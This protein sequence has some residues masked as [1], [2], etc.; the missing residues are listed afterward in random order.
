MPDNPTSRR[1]L[2]TGATG[3]VGG[4]VLRKLIATGH[5]PV[6]LVRDLGKFER[7]TASLS[8]SEI[9]G[10]EGSI[11]SRSAL[12]RAAEQSDSAIHLV[13]VIMERGKQT[14]SRVHYEGTKNVLKT[15]L[16][17]GIKRYI[18]MSALGARPDA[19]SKYH[20]TKYM[21][22]EAV[23][24]SGLNWTIFQ[25]SV[26]HGPDGEFMELMKTFAC[27]LLPPVMPYFGDGSHRL[28]PVDVR[29]V[30]ECFVKALS[31]VNTIHRTYT[32]GGPRSFSWK[33][34]YQTCQRLIPG[35]KQWKPTIGQPVALAKFLAMTV[36][37]LPM[38]IAK[39][40]K[41]RFNTAQVQMSQEDSTCDIAPAESDLGISFRDFETE[42]AC[43][44]DQIR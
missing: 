28:Q 9:V 16:D 39:F 5:V 44:A 35:A 23:R 18:H 19:V 38:P 33:E 17:A 4:Q 25:P 6:C 37:K 1:I 34:L 7:Q 41:L 26:I 13:G 27:S 40:D 29:D 36:M 30:A 21:A 11:F 42:L 2:L 3:F 22:E 10:I 31:L 15:C 8:N 32:L 12:A 24:K 14:F 20:L 43:Y